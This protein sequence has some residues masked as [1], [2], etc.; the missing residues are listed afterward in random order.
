MLWLVLWDDGVRVLPRVEVC[1]SERE[2]VA[3]ARKRLGGRVRAVEVE[4][5]VREA[6][7]GAG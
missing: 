3:F 2:A 5:M 6:R 7:G 1:R 4:W